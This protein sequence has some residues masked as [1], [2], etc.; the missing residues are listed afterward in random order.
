MRWL[1]CSMGLALPG[2]ALGQST[3]SAERAQTILKTYCY[4]CHGEKGANEGG[5]NYIVDLKQLVARRKVVP[6]DATKS[7]MLQRM[8]DA[9]DPMPPLEEKNRP[10]PQEIA[11]VKSWI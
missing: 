1:I 7:R 11:A 9:D 4:R 6:G 10:T 3:P 2:A 5:L 8:L